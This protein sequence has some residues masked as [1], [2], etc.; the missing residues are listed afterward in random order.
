MSH[1]ADDVVVRIFVTLLAIEVCAGVI[2]L[3]VYKAPAGTLPPL[4]TK[5][6]IAFWIGVV[7]VSLS[8]VSLMRLV[9][10]GRTRRALFLGLVANLVTIAPTLA[11]L[12]VG[13]RAIA[14]RH[15][16]GVA[17]GSVQLRPTWPE[18]VDHSRSVMSGGGGSPQGKTYFVYDSELGWTVGTNRRTSDG[19][20]FSSIEGVRSAGPDI[21]VAAFDRPR[22]ALVGD[23]NAFSLEVPFEQSW[24]YY[25]QQALGDRTQVLNFGVDGYGVD[26]ML[27]RYRRDVRPWRPKVVLIGFIQHDLVRS[28]AVYPFVGLNWPGYLVKP[29]FV[30]ED[31]TLRQINS[32]L[33]APQRIFSAGDL[34]ELP[35]VS[36]DLTIHR[37]EWRFRFDHV[38]YVIR[39]LTSRFS[40]GL[41]EPTTAELSGAA[42]WDAAI[43]LN[44][45]LLSEL[46]AAVKRD[47]AT[48]L[49]VYLPDDNGDNDL[50][51]RTLE[52][53][54]ARRV[55]PARCLAEV[56]AD[57]RRVARGRHYA[58][59]GNQ[60]L[61]KCT[62]PDVDVALH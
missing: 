47:G 18:L 39:V 9:W 21:R 24:G 32:P 2:G 58:G 33:P 50:A 38:P 6:G 37:G 62:A 3:G 27:L 34:D 26:Q 19:L 10:D 54:T 20:Y 29:R 25:L 43:S 22:V 56:P 48:P 28:M 4:S 36:H 60:A 15:T 59:P 51:R 13:A 57:R 11:L 16:D 42:D 35:F 44:A 49:L 17:V 46:V 40:P 12:E 45:R 52:R 8:L 55:D 61:A 1:R 30:I 5:P 31:G 53:V 41:V 23:S 14:R 7:G